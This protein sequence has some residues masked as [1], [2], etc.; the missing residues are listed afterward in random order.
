MSNCELCG[1]PMTPGEEMFKFH[2]HSG[3]CPKPPLDRKTPSRVEI[4]YGLLW[5]TTTDDKRIHEARHL[6]LETM[7]K[8]GQERGINAAKKV[9]SN[10]T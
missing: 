4:A 8:E 6:L 5:M 1:E 2:G 9:T 7:D 3:N 10:I